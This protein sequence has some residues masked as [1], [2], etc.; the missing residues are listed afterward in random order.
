MRR[1]STRVVLLGLLV[2]AL[3]CAGI[4]SRFASSDPDGLTRVSQD[5]G[6]ADTEVTHHSGLFDYGSLSGIVGVLVVLAIAGALTYALRRRGRD[7]ADDQHDS[8]V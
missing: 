2:A 4:V 1:P 5:K 6:F 7:R 8:R 3:V